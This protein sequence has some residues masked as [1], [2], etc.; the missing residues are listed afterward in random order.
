MSQERNIL[1][2]AFPERD[3]T[4]EA[5][6]EITD[7][8]PGL[9]QAAVV[10]RDGDGVLR[11][12]DTFSSTPG[13]AD[14][15]S[16]GLLGNVIAVVGGPLGV[17]LGWT[18]GLA[19]GEVVDTKVDT[20]HAESGIEDHLR[21]LSERIPVGGTA[22]FVDAVEVRAAVADEL[23]ARHHGTLTRVP[24]DAA[25]ADVRAAHHATRAAART[26]REEHLKARRA[27]LRTS[28]LGNPFSHGPG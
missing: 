1:L 2:F 28:S 22:L 24:A 15:L 26:A 20:T 21:M 25:G 5:F 16:G 10:E 27:A 4:V 9:L 3:Q 14:S 23:A 6:A 13:D 11:T 12:A 8:L 19:A 7:L 17:L 18:P